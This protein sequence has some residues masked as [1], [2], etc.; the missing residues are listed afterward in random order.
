[1]NIACKNPKCGKAIPP[2]GIFCPYC[3][4]KQVTAPGRKRRG[5]GSGYAYRRGKTWTLR[6]ILGYTVNEAGKVVRLERT[7]GGY[8][9]KAEAL[10]HVEEL[11]NQKVR[12]A[13]T[14]AELWTIYK[15][16]PYTKL[17]SSKQTAYRI[18][19]GKLADIS[20]TPIDKL[21]IRDL[22]DCVAAKAPTHYPARDMKTVLG[23]L[24]DYALAEQYVS[25][26]LPDF[27]ELPALEESEPEP[28]SEIEIHSLW[29]GYGG[30]DWFAG[31][32]LLMIYTGMMPGE[33]L[34]L[35]FDM[36]DWTR[37]E[38]VGAGKK[39]KVRKKTPLV[40]ADFILPVL[41]D[42]CQRSHTRKG[43]VVG[44]N[45]DKFYE[46][47]YL[48]L[49]R[50]KCRRLTPYSCRHTTATALA[51]GNIAPSVIQKIMRHAKFT[52]T[53]RYIHPDMTSMKEAVNALQPAPATG[54]D[55]AAAG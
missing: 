10:R 14:L 24:W 29:N 3:G 20:A 42:L 54:K 39:T 6:V 51:L 35:R 17:G 38:I 37:C 46:E 21:G 55:P 13:P 1:V 49:E 15:A 25:V 27:I 9:T 26:R 44:M 48:C 12:K 11:K 5:N 32:V 41:D 28:F 23:K 2:D 53:Q 33:L 30:G 4:Q 7:K 22:T 36:I 34:D 50:N 16:G 43:K 45:K 8:P 52:T 19:W 47:Y 18:A 31:F 40:L